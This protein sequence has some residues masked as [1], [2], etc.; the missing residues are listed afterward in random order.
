MK[1][2]TQELNTSTIV[3]YFKKK[4]TFFYR[5]KCTLIRI[6]NTKPFQITVHNVKQIKTSDEKINLQKRFV[7]KKEKKQ[8]R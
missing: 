7:L 1:T 3:G 4:K 8:Q 6:P 5:F 2:N